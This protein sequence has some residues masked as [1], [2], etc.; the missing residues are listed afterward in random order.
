MYRA[1]KSG[2]IPVL[3]CLLLLAACSENPDRTGTYQNVSDSVPGNSSVLQLRGDYQGTW[4][5]ELDRIH[6][7]WR[8]E[9]QI[10][11]LD[12][13]NGT[14][15]TGEFTDQGIRIKIPGSGTYSFEKIST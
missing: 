5:T 15:I 3:F 2:L 7:Y 8:V 12:M 4:E 13:E 14:T 10:L 6:F 1:F 9:G 11:R